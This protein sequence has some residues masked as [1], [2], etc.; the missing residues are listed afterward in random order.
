MPLQVVHQ[1]T[2]FDGR[3]AGVQRARIEGGRRSFL[4][5]GE[6]CARLRSGGR[7][8]IGRLS[9]PRLKQMYSYKE[10]RHSFDHHIMY[11]QDIYWNN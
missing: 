1:I 7:L 2:S 11:T 8:R 5:G 4:S 9:V 3:S 10:L 6:N